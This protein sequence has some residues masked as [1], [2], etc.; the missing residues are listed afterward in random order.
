MINDLRL[1]LR[2]LRKTPGFTAVVVLTLA[3]GIG[4]N[5]AIF[6]VV[7]GVLLR[8]LPYEEPGQLVHLWED[9]SGKGQGKNSVAGAQFADWKRQITTMEGIA[10]IRRDYLNLTGDGRPERLRVHRVSASY[11]Q[12]LRLTP[13]LGRGFLPDADQP[14]REKVVVLTDQLWRRHFGG[15]TDVLGRAI[16]LGGE[17]YSVIGILPATPRL[18]LDAEALVPFVVGSEGWH[19]SRTTTDFE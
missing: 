16:R 2:S 7:N 5:T 11:L 6:S 9:P 15:A 1:A 14:G 12:I 10:A 18:P 19:G 8:A 17:S 4:A 13:R 3:V